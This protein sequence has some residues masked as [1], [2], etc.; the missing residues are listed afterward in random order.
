M[1]TS[2]IRR[3]A[4]SALLAV[5]RADFPGRVFNAPLAEASIAGVAAGMAIAGYKPIIEIQF[6]D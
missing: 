4:F 2:P 3:A 6:A 1:K 5:S